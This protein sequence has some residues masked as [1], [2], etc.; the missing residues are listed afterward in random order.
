MFLTEGEKKP[1]RKGK[2]LR[3]KREFEAFKE[4][5]KAAH[6]WLEWDYFRKY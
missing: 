5:I 3:R 1:R 4:G 2:S 6:S